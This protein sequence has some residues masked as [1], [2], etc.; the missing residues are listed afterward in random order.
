[1]VKDFTS[2]IEN[3]VGEIKRLDILI[4]ISEITKSFE[5]IQRLKDIFKSIWTKNE[6]EPTYNLEAIYEEFSILLNISGLPM[7]TKEH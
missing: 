2:N 4:Y 7:Y 3:F 1:M 5:E 6:N